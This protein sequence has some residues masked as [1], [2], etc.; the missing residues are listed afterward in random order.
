MP[1]FKILTMK[2]TAFVL[3]I[4][5]LFFVSCGMDSQEKEVRAAFNLFLDSLEKSDI[6][7]A[8]KAAPFI[9]GMTADSR[10]ELITQFMRL[11]NT[12]YKLDITRK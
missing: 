10:A 6:M 5:S 9:S 4:V 2:K 11:K 12:D 8:E 1:P 7:G 3:L